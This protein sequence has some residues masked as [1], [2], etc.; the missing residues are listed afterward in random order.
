MNAQHPLAGPADET[1]KELARIAGSKR[2]NQLDASTLLGE[3]AMLLGLPR[4]PCGQSYSGASRLLPCNNGWIAVTLP[5]KSDW[6]LIP[7]WLER[8]SDE[9]WQGLQ[10]SLQTQSVDRVVE[11]G[12]LLGLA[13]AKASIPPHISSLSPVKPTYSYRQESESPLVLD[14]SALWAGPLCGY[15]LHLAGARVIKVESTTRPDGARLGN[16][17]FYSLLNQ[18]KRS[19]AFNFKE[20]EGRNALRQLIEKADIVIESSRPRALRQ[21]GVLPEELVRKRQCLVWV[22]I[23][24]YGRQEPEAN[25]SAYGDDAGAAAGLCFLMWKATGQ[26]QFAGDAIAD[27]LTGIETAWRAWNAWLGA[28]SELISPSMKDVVTLNLSRLSQVTELPELLCRWWH[29][30]PLMVSNRPITDTV[31]AFGDSTDSVFQELKLC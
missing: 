22:S 6:E 20:I 4:P 7:A 14:L 24:G 9:S 26:Y 1:L 23:T 28:K 12:R 3:R 30:Q 5:R 27:P 18:G 19:V 31:E 13:V 10:E 21:L 2:L 11:R 29:N 8:D 17:D 25:W 16:Q 15:L